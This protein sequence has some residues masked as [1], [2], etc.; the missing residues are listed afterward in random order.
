VSDWYDAGYYQV[1]PAA[2]PTGP[3]SGLFKVSRGGSHSTEVYYLRSGNRAANLPGER[4]WCALFSMLFLSRI[5][6]WKPPPMIDQDRLQGH[7]HKGS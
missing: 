5:Y 1:A 2:D 4:S 7:T 6:L 3:S